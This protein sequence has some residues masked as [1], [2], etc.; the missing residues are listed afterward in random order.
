VD[1]I[2][3]SAERRQEALRFY[4]LAQEAGVLTSV[5]DNSMHGGVHLMA[6]PRFDDIIA[7][8]LYN[9]ITPEMIAGARTSD[10]R[11]W[12][13]NLASGGWDARRDRFV[14]GLF[15]E[16]CAAEGCAQW[17]FQWP[18]GN[19]DPYEAAAAGESSGYHY[20][21]PAPDGPLPTLA[22]EGVREG[23][24]DARYLA[25]LRQDSPESVAA[26]LDDIE[27]LGTTVEAYVSR[28]S[29]SFL[30]VRRWRMAR[31]AMA[32]TDGR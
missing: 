11:L 2:G 6:Q 22:L 9:F 17:A 8:R 19:T 20:A 3:N 26:R 16:R 1:E 21:L 24:D 29:G 5:T 4:R 14:F 13:Y 23:V 18:N 28:H 31:E 32:E 15:T 12:L 27:P 25:L 30:D 10:D 7:M